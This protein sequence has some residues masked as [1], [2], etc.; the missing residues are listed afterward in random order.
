MRTRRRTRTGGQL[1]KE[2]RAFAALRDGSFLLFIDGSGLLQGSFFA[3]A[4]WSV[5]QTDRAGNRIKAAYG[6]VPWQQ[7]PTQVARD[8]EDYALFQATLL[9]RGEPD[10]YCDCAGTVGLAQAGAPAGAEARNPRAHL[11]TKVW[12]RCETVKVF[13]TKAHTTEEDLEVGVT[14]EWERQGNRWADHHAKLGAAKHPL[15]RRQLDQLAGLKAIQVSMLRWAA[16]QEAAVQDQQQRDY[17]VFE[18]HERPAS[19][20]PWRDPDLAQRYYHHHIGHTEALAR[21]LFPDDHRGHELWTARLLR[22]P[23]EQCLVVDKAVVMCS[24]CGCYAHARV[25]ELGFTC[26]GPGAMSSTRLARWNRFRGGRFPKHGSEYLLDDMSRCTATAYAFLARSWIR[27]CPGVPGRVPDT[28]VEHFGTEERRRAIV[29]T[30]GASL[31]DAELIGA[32]KRQAKE[33]ARAA[34]AKRRGHAAPG[35]DFSE[36]SD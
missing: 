2:E 13:K 34:K 31:E 26:R 23:G 32:S 35:H 27:R 7:A 29:A 19:Q 12:S 28:G 1:T 5:V 10:I 20:R 25:Q 11:W 15:P 24:R 21:D 33:Q 14:T 9:A 8:G 4:G 18:F 17:E 36:E 3:R 30:T 6:A 16:E 22:K